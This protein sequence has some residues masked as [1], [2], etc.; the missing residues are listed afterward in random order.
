[1]CN[2]ISLVEYLIFLFVQYCILSDKIVWHLC[3]AANRL[4]LLTFINWLLKLCAITT[5][6]LL[7][8][9]SFTDVCCVDDFLQ[10]H[11]ML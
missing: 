9:S 4:T 1:M 10:E 8:P 11:R 3:G 6:L 5:F 7:V 2:P